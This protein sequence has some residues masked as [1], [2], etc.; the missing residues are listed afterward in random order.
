MKENLTEYEALIL[1]EE[2]FSQREKEGQ[3]LTNVITPN[4]IGANERPDNYEFMKAPIIKVSRVDKY[5]FN[6]EL[7]SSKTIPMYLL[8]YC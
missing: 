1:K 8:Q 7:L 5:Y 2:L 4:A 3:I 6:K